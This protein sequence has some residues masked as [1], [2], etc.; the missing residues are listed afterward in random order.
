[1]QGQRKPRGEESNGELADPLKVLA[2]STIANSDP[3]RNAPRSKLRT[4][5]GSH[6]GS[7]A[8]AHRAT[9]PR[10]SA[11]KKRSSRNALKSGIFSK[12][13]LVGNESRSEYQSLLDGLREDLQPQGMLETM[14]VE[15]LAAVIWRIRRSLRAESA[16]IDDA[17][18]FNEVDTLQ[19]QFLEVWDRSRAGEAAGG[20]LRPSSN[21]FLIREAINALKL[22]RGSV[23]RFGFRK[24]EDPWL[25]R[26][27]FGL[28]HD[29]AA[30]L[31]IFR[32]FQLNSQLAT[33]VLKKPG[34][35]YSP[36]ELKKEMIEILDAEI[37]R[38]EAQEM[39]Q[40]SM[41]EQ[42]APSRAL[43]ALVP[44]Q[45]AMER[46]VRYETHLSREFDRI[47]NRLERVQRM[48]RGQPGP[49]TLN[50]NI[51]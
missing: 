12:A 44:P 26:K 51:T 50:L 29:Q 17:V 13:V 8:L 5:A 30:P 32:S 24:D 15:N 1:M 14:L 39:L 7:S 18:G 21:R 23:A 2:G 35:S 6:Q 25:L 31:G 34:I 33:G 47:L 20:M 42:R 16:V 43:A 19:A 48:R 41:D 22:F 27:I 36:E 3:S 10:T 4:A 38:L 45:D 46:F 40:E 49:P 11:G 37:K 9:G 28:D